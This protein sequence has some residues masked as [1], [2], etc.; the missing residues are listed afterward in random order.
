MRR[1]ALSI[2]IALC[3][4]ASADSV[5]SDPAF[6]GI[7]MM[8]PPNIGGC[9]ITEVTANSPAADIGIQK[10]DEIASVDGATL[11]PGRACD[12]LNA[13]IVGHQPDDSV[14]LTIVRNGE[15]RVV[16][17]VLATRSQVL[18][19]RV[20]QRLG[21]GA[22][23]E[24]PDGRH[25]E[26]GERRGHAL[27]VGAFD[28][29]CAGCVALVDR[30]AER[31]ARRAPSAEALAVTSDPDPDLE[32]RARTVRS[33]RGSVPMALADPDTFDSLTTA[34][35][36]RVFFTVMDCRGVV[37]LIAPIAPDADDIDAAIDDVLAG[38]EQAE[39][40][41]GRR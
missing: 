4:T 37:K 29:R 6:L 36:N 41:R 27:I 1:L 12:E 11:D 7:G 2:T 24:D 31:L 16:H 33:M 15:P 10:G 19:R 40:A 30:V 26:L 25:W 20:G 39:H 14:E 38:A 22:V 23:V 35:T 9:F 28:E 32:T 17:P 3:A 34:E 18:E 13:A 21:V 8:S 5:R